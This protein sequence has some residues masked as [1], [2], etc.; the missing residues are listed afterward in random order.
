MPRLLVQYPGLDVVAVEPNEAMIGGFKKV[1]P[2]VPIIHGAAQQLP[3]DDNFVDGIFV[4]QVT[5]SSLTEAH[6]I[7]MHACQSYVFLKASKEVPQIYGNC[8]V[9]WKV[10]LRS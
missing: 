5:V 8:N 1:L 3:F 7:L 10:H 6:N 9:R 4:G 2:E